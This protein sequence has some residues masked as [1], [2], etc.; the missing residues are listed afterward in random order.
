MVQGRRRRYV[1]AMMLRWRAKIVRHGVGL[2]T[3]QRPSRAIRASRTMTIS[4]TAV[5]RWSLSS[6][7]LPQF[8]AAAIG[9]P[10]ATYDAEEKETTD[11]CCETDNKGKVAIDPGGDLLAH[12]TAFTLALQS[13]SASTIAKQQIIGTHIIAASTTCTSS[14]V[15]EVLLETIA[16]TSPKLGTCAAEHAVTVITSIRV[17]T[18]GITA[19]DSFALLVTRRA[20]SACTAQSIAT[21]CAIFLILILWTVGAVSGTC[22]LGVAVTDTRA[23]DCAC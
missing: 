22:L 19:H 17:V 8:A 5:W 21:T 20:L 12:G 18:L 13:V 11:A 6:S 14:T 10:A 16:Y 23:T 2:L 7:I 4:L 9:A 15:Q 1:C 3:H